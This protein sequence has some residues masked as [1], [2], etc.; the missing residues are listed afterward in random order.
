VHRKLAFA[1][2]VAVLGCAPSPARVS[3]PTT[4]SAPT[5]AVREDAP[6][7]GVGPT[8]ARADEDLM[9]T[10][11]R[12]LDGIRVTL[13]GPR[14][15][16]LAVVTRGDPAFDASRGMFT[17]TLHN[18]SD[19]ERRL[20]IDELRR[21]LVRVYGNP[22]TR[23]ESIDNRSAPPRAVG[24]VE[25]LPRGATR[26]IQVPFAYPASIATMEHGAAQLRFCVRWESGWLRTASYPSDAVD[27]NPSFELCADLRIVK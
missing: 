27:W 21:S 2:L 24:I 14:S 1:P 17:L 11:N 26:D 7:A 23:A 19:R 18:E 3:P 6:I 16:P 9:S 25:A 4:P 20:P 12:L 15:L 22:A 8:A 10:T 5:P 13:S